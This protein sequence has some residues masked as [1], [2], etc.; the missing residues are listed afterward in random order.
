MKML[1][2]G[3]PSCSY[4][5]MAKTFC[6]KEN[7]PYEYKNLESEQDLLE[8]QRKIGNPVKTVP[9]IFVLEQGFAEYIGGYNN[10]VEKY[11]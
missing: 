4:C 10:L 3:T 8:L 5:K 7:I 2:Y 11:G 1:I 6:E 9:Q